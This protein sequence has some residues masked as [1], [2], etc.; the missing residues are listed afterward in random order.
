[1]IGFWASLVIAHVYLAGRVSPKVATRIGAT[2]LALAIFSG[3]A[4]VLL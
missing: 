3:I 4:E 2:Y 1:M